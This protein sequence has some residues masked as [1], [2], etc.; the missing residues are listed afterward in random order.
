MTTADQ[1]RLIL[2]KLRELFLAHP[3]VLQDTVSVRLETIESATAV[4]RI[5]AGVDTNNYQ[6]YLAV[7]EDLNL[8]IIELVHNAGAIFSGAGQVL[9]LR[10]F[11]QASQEKLEEVESILNDWHKQE[12]FPFPDITDDRKSALKGTLE[13]PP[14]SRAT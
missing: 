1:L 6:E 9:Q 3:M 14:G 4:L 11:Y 7:A 12:A 13:Y 2:G 8:R 10:D 5:D